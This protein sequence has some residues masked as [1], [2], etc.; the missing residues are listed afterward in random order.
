MRLFSKIAFLAA[1]VSAL[2]CHDSVAPELPTTYILNRVNGQSVPFVSPIP[3]NPTIVSGGLILQSNGRATLI[4]RR[5]QWGTDVTT[6]TNYTY[7]ITGTDIAF[8]YY[9]SPDLVCLELPTV[10]PPRGTIAGGRI[11]LDM[12]PGG[13]GLTYEFQFSAPD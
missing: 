1:I 13:N 5:L 9:C 4:Q 7:T 8:T 2:A 11:T 10:P 6:T 3:E 12:N